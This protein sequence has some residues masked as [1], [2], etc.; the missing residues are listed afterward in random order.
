M[1]GLGAAQV[2]V[3]RCDDDPGLHREQVDANKRDAHPSV[4]DYPFVE[5]M[6]EY[7]DDAGARRATFEFGHGNGRDNEPCTVTRPYTSTV[8]VES[9]RYGVR[10]SGP[11]FLLPEQC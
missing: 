11:D 3:N 10:Q 8:D 1:N 5:N 9:L 7:V 6:V 4:D 2:C